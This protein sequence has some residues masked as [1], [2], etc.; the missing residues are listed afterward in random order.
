MAESGLLLLIHGES[1]DPQVDIFDRES[2]FLPVLKQILAGVPTLKIVLEHVTTAAGVEF[3]KQHS[4]GQLA[5]TITAHHLL[6]SRNSLF[7]G[8]LQP[9]LYCLPILKHESDRL[10]LV[11]SIFSPTH[12]HLFFAGT[13]SAPHER[14]NK[15]RSGCAAGCF[16]A[17]ATVELYLESLAS[18]VICAKY[19]H[20]AAYHRQV[21]EDFL[22]KNG[23]TFYGLQVN[24]S[25]TIRFSRTP[26]QV[27][28]SMVRY[29]QSKR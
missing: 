27:P 29:M 23:A 16:T 6:Y 3:V 9:H 22:T 5:A 25:R 11:E 14:T 2:S 4:N 21:I 15:E 10:A 24:S 7:Q 26:M 28:N 18:S 13:D 20:D 12:R 8:G 1:T 19:K 17:F